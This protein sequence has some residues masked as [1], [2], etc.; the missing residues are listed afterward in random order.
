MVTKEFGKNWGTLVHKKREKIP[1]SRITTPK[2]FHEFVQKMFRFHPI[3]IIGV[4][5]EW[6]CEIEEW[7]WLVE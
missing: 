1:S 4:W 7:V 2:E 3:E 6:M 5:V